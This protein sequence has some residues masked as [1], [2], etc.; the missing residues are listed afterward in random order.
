MDTM[1]KIVLV[2]GTGGLAMF[3]YMAAL[4]IRALRIYIRK[5]RR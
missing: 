1:S 5:E 2:F 3:L 4:I